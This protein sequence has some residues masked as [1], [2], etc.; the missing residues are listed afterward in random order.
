MIEEYVR[1]SGPD[2]RSCAACRL[3]AAMEGGEGVL[4][5][6]EWRPPVCFP[7]AWGVTAVLGGCRLVDWLVIPFEFLEG[8]GGFGVFVGSGVVVGSGFV[9]F[10][11][12]MVGTP[13]GAV[14]ALETPLE[15]LLLP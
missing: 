13:V 6:L 9:V 2:V 14:P 12:T 8:R 3:A 1:L 7:V 5:F 10:V 15:A 4:Q 11:L